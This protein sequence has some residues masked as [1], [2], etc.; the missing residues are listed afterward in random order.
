MPAQPMTCDTRAA[1]DSI[2]DLIRRAEAGEEVVITR[3][4]K[5]VARLVPALE[6]AATRR[7]GAW[8][9]RVHV[10]PDFDRLSDEELR[11][12]ESGDLP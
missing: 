6:N 11:R 1:E 4:G 7:G 2:A 9:G 3:D 12:F 8:R 5:P 10:A